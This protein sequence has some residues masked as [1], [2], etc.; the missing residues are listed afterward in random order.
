MHGF[1]GLI[2]SMAS[3]ISS[4]IG[5]PTPEGV[6]REHAVSTIGEASFAAELLAA[7]EAAYRIIRS[8]G[9]A[10]SDAAD[11][12]QDASIR[13]WRHRDD[14]RGEFRPWFLA[15][16]YREAKR[17]R[18]RW[19]TL[20]AFWT[21]HAEAAPPDEHSAEVLTALRT[22]PRRQRVALTLRYDADMSTAAVGIVMG[23]SEPAAKQLL[24]R[25]R[26][27]LRTALAE[28]ATEVRS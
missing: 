4:E 18:R 8:V 6:G 20:P 16:A 3:S 1:A 27:S 10:P 11:A 19:L 25:A 24:A 9:L 13:A 21:V 28:S 7:S 2:H 22:L 17:P 26:E 23:I 12:L 14:C 5:R 15:I